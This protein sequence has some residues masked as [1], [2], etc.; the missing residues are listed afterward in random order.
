MW[1]D[2][3]NPWQTSTDATKFGMEEFIPPYNGCNPLPSNNI[4]RYYLIHGTGSQTGPYMHSAETPSMVDPNGI[5][6]IEVSGEFWSQSVEMPLAVCGGQPLFTLRL[7]MFALSLEYLLSLP[8][9]QC[10][11][12]DFYVKNIILRT[13]QN[14]QK[15]HVGLKLEFDLLDKYW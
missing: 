4:H 13:Q 1:D 14:L 15:T 8:R 11:N 6:C 5:Y 12:I 7:P 9:S 2:I 3:T 10:I